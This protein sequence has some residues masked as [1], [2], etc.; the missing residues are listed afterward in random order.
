MARIFYHLLQHAIGRAR[1]RQ[2]IERCTSISPKIAYQWTMLIGE[3]R[4]VPVCAGD[5]VATT[6]LCAE[7]IVAAQGLCRFFR[8]CRSDQWQ[9]VPKGV[10]CQR[11][12]RFSLSLSRKIIYIYIYRMIVAKLWQCD[13]VFVFFRDTF[14]KIG[15]VPVPQALPRHNAVQIRKKADTCRHKGL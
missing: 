7:D 3:G 13:S 12:A 2:T 1:K 11:A 15:T 14:G 9:G 10:T 5:S 8:L 4:F 6:E